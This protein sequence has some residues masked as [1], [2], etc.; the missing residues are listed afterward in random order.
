LHNDTSFV[1]TINIQLRVSIV[2]TWQFDDSQDV[3][4]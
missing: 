3:K 4:K 2:N 1:F